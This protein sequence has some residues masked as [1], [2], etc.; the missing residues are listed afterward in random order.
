MLLV[1]RRIF[2]QKSPSFLQRSPVLANK[3]ALYF[4]EKALSYTQRKWTCK[5]DVVFKA[6]NS[7]KEHLFPAKEPYIS[8]KE[9]CICKK[10]LRI[11]A[12]EPYWYPEEI[13]SYK[14]CSISGEIFSA[15]EPCIFAKETYT[16]AKEPYISVKGPYIFQRSPIFP[17][18]VLLYSIDPQSRVL[19]YFL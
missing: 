18:K 3:G 16:S 15:N 7:A 14:C 5:G 17:G 1:L 6:N 4:R 13:K 8:A 12:K 2:P 19:N 11:S 10:E 9:P